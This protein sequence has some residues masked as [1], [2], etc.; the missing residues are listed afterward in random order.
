MTGLQTRKRFIAAAVA[1]GLSAVVSGTAVPA[2]AATRQSSTLFLNGAGSTFIQPLMVRWAF[3]YPNSLPKTEQVR[4]NYQGVGSGAGISDLTNGIV[5]FACSDATMTDAQ[6]KAAG[7][8]VLHIPL[9]LGPVAITYNLPSFNGNLKLDG[10]TLAAIY[11]GKITNWNDKAIAALNPGASLPNQAIVVAHRADGSGT[12]FIFTHYL[13]AVDS[14][15]NSNIGA[16]TAVNWPTGQGAKG[17]SGVASVVKQSPGGI[18]YV[19]LSYALSQHLPVIYMK[20]KAGD[21]VPPSVAGA[22]ADAANAGTLPAD[23]RAIIVDSPGAASYPISGFSWG[24]LHQK[25]PNSKY[26]QIV[27]FFWW[28]I[29]QGQMYSTSGALRYSPLPANVVKADEAKLKSITYNG[30]PIL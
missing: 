7:G 26:V 1:V 30:K 28:A 3:V 12:T 19:E 6:I 24:L 17:T 13:S 2:N 14:Y 21:F 11:E 15:W 4:I 18:G 22:A 5:D 8:D 16:A 29:H 23:L 25:A 27:N 10:P 9:T 20:N